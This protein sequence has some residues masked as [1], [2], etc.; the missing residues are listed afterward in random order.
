VWVEKCIRRRMIKADYGE[1]YSMDY[2]EQCSMIKIEIT[3][4]WLLDCGP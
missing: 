4:N 2:G 3:K 1:Q